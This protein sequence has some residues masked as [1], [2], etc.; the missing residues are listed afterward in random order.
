MTD[1]KQEETSLTSPLDRNPDKSYLNKLRHGQPTL[2]ENETEVAMK[3]LNDM[4]ILSKY[5]KIEKSY[6]DPPV[7]LQQF[8][9]FSFVPSS[10]AKP[11]DMG[12]YGFA[13]IRGSYATI[14]EANERSE[15]LIRNCDTYHK[16]YHT[17]V[18]RPFPVTNSSKYSKEVSEVEL[19]KKMTDTYSEDIKQKKLEEQKD[20]YDM[21]EREEKLLQESKNAEAGLP[22]TSDPY[23]IYTEKRVKLAQ[24]SWTYIET[25]K[26]MKQM[27]EVILKTKK[28]IDELE[29]TSDD[30]KKQYFER[31]M[32]ARKSANLPDENVE[33]S[34]MKYMVEDYE[35]D[36]MKEKKE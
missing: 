21:K 4:S 5:P 16:I 34:F 7:N 35:F 8:S 27:M 24:V 26:K 29:K 9:L 22:Y 10:G 2:T 18:G 17:Y 25:E 12:V 1:N 6:A 23:E 3:E 33:T 30:Y 31:Y 19:K 14:Q 13:K 11:D 15:Y 36:F 20:I 32:K 28:E